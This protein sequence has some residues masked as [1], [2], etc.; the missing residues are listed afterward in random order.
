MHRKDRATRGRVWKG[1]FDL[2][3][4]PPRSKQGRVQQFRP[5]RRATDENTFGGFNAVHLAED[6]IYCGV[7]VKGVFV[8]SPSRRNSVDFIEKDDAWAR[9]PRLGEKKANALCR[10]AL[11]FAQHFGAFHG[12]EVHRALTGNGF[13]QNRLSRAWRPIKKDAPRDRKSTRLTPV[14]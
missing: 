9:F 14:T 10:L 8:S 5:I 7:R 1:D 11:P 4:K 6:L 13:S 2:V 12:D 3:I